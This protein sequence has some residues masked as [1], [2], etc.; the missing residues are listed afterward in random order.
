MEAIV[1]G[2]ASD[3]PTAAALLIMLWMHHRRD[4]SRDERFSGIAERQIESDAK[5]R[6][7]LASM[8]NAVVSLV[9]EM[10]EARHRRRDEE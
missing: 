3:A 8:Q 6:S 7:A 1:E 4:E 5:T 10:R 9:D 2:L